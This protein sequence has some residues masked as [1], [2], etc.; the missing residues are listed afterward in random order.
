MTADRVLEWMGI[1]REDKDKSLHEDI[2]DSVRVGLFNIDN[3]KED[4]DERMD[5]VDNKLNHV[6]E[7]EENARETLNDVEE[8]LDEI[9]IRIGILEFKLSGAV[10]LGLI[11]LAFISAQDGR[12]LVT[13]SAAILAVMFSI[14]TLVTLY[15]GFFGDF[16]VS[17]LLKI[18]KIL[19]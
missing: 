8:K 15:R 12:M 9:D 18:K 13:Y 14:E 19:T 2:K 1:E 17:Y 7:V 5:K 16:I 6:E 4:I 11:Y 10:I 3:I